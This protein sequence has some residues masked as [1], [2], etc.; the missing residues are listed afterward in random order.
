MADEGDVAAALDQ[1]PEGARVAE[2]VLRVVAPAEAERRAVAQVAQ[3]RVRLAVRQVLAV[4][5]ARNARLER[6]PRTRKQFSS[7]T[8]QGPAHYKNLCNSLRPGAAKFISKIF[9]EN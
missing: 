1:T 3:V 8:T 2:I 4:H 9:G 6:R 7:V 5:R